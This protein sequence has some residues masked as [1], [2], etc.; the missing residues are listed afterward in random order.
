[1]KRFLAFLFLTV[2]LIV[3]VAGLFPLPVVKAQGYEYTFEGPYDELTEDDVDPVILQFTDIDGWIFSETLTYPTPVVVNWTQLKSVSWNFSSTLGSIR[4]IEFLPEDG[5]GE[6]TETF[7][8]LIANPDVPVNS[9]FFSVADFT[10][11]VEYLEITRDGVILERKSLTATGVV[12]FNMQLGITYTLSVVGDLGTFS[13]TF[14]ASNVVN[15]Q[16]PILEGSFGA[17]SSYGNQEV[18]KA[19]R[20]ITDAGE[21]TEYQE[22]VVYYNDP[23]NTTDYVVLF[24]YKLVG[25]TEQL[26]YDNDLGY[27]LN[28]AFED[29]DASTTYIV[30]LISYDDEDEVINEWTQ[31]I[32]PSTGQ[33]NVWEG[34]LNPLTSQ[35]PTLPDTSVLP[36]GYKIAELPAAIIVA[37]VLAIFSFRS[38]ELG[39]FLS[40]LIALILVGL[41][42]LSVSLPAFGFALFLS[43]FIVFSEGK[44]S[45]PM[46]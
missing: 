46:L 5:T 11:S 41:G 43:V 18:F 17:S 39:C 7:Y 3:L 28:F 40:W 27:P 24:L 16:L 8:I 34:L 36:E 4:T 35:V 21:E 37:F 26:L 15:T 12:E 44:K 33:T 9:Y 19:Y 10:G 45:E 1:M 2:F 6:G 25:T 23:T 22:I 13:Q 31:T 42:W 38:P 20:N 32:G 29:A 30:N 14:T